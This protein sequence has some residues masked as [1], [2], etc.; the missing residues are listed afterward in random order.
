MSDDFIREHIEDLLRNIRT[1]VLVKLLRPY[2]RVRLPFITQKLNLEPKEVESL[3]VSC[4]LDGTIAGKID[5][6]ENT[7]ILTPGSSD[8][9]TIVEDRYVGM[10]RLGENLSNLMNLIIFRSSVATS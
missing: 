3:L 6:A 8:A 10:D 5:Q 7:L 9:E 2:T 1:E 4:I